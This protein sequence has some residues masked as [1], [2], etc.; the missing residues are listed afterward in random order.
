MHNICCAATCYRKIVRRKLHPLS[1]HLGMASANSKEIKEFTQQC[2]AAITQ[3]DAI[4]MMRGIQTYLRSESHV[5]SHKTEVAWC[6]NDAKLIKLAHQKGVQ[7][8][9]P[10]I[11]VPSLIN[12]SY[13]FNLCKECSIIKW[14]HDQGIATYIFDWGALNKADS[15]ETIAQQRLDPAIQYI[16]N[17]SHNNTVNVL[18]Y[19][20]GGTILLSHNHLLK[21]HINKIIVLAAPWDFAVENMTLSKY[22]RIASPLVMSE[23]E[24]KQMLPAEWI[25]ALFA[26]IDPNGAAQKFIKFAKNEKT[27]KDKNIF[28]A[29]E[30]WLNDGIDLPYEI[31]HECIQNW[32]TKNQLMNIENTKINTNIMIVASKKDKLVPYESAIAATKTLHAKTIHVHEANTG[33]IG[34]VAGSNAHQEVWQPIKEWL[35]SK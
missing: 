27:K 22:V 16:K 17:Q 30:D 7:N 32:F 11:L 13:I 28:V 21:T 25:Q 31:A 3:N 23:L 12:K 26:S 2:S 18:G 4:E 24:K 15:I 5:E 19:C 35:I 6:E 34:L 10:L 14:F 29:V 9:T 1:V 20:M 33:H 8:T